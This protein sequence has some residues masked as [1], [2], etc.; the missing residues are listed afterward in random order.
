MYAIRSYYARSRSNW[1]IKSG[2]EYKFSEN[3]TFGFNAGIG[4]FNMIMAS[5]KMYSEW[6]SPI[7]DTTI[8]HTDNN[9]IV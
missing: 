5:N 6:L 8:Y 3:N 9:N 7:F 4:N 1:N 2:F